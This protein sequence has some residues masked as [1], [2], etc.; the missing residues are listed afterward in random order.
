V[1]EER[2]LLSYTLTD[3]GSLSGGSSRAYGLNDAGQVVGEATTPDGTR[4]FLWDSGVMTDLGTLGRFGTRADAINQAG[5]VVGSSSG[6]AF[7]WQ[8]GVLND[9]L[10]L[11]GAATGINNAGQVV[12]WAQLTSSV[13]HAFLWQDGALTDLGT[14]DGGV[15]KADAVNDGRGQ[16]VGSA[17]V[18]D[19]QHAFLWQSGVM[20]DLGTLPNDFHSEATAI[21]SAGHV[22]GWSADFDLVGFQAFFSDGGPLTA[23]GPFGSMALGINDSDQVVGSMRSSD[24]FGTHAFLYADG[25]VTDLNG[26]IPPDSRFVLE[27]A[28]AINNSGQIVGVGFSRA[29]NLPRAFLLTPDG[30]PAPHGHAASSTPVDV[31]LV[32]GAPVTPPDADVPLESPRVAQGRPAL[33]GPLSA[34]PEFAAGQVSSPAAGTP[35]S[36]AVSR[37]AADK[38]FAP[39]APDMLDALALD[40]FAWGPVG[41][42]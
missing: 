15:S 24:T 26:L 7:L 32:R 34:G 28:Q 33:R 18:G 23:I 16:V 27:A 39:A 30:G 25:V 19:A 31:A 20:T 42:W 38:L 11:G 2:C 17:S 40:T 8:D 9:L 12:G 4:A 10:G 35:S 5:Q 41:D 1:L 37:H 29:V 14:L 22:A 21:N 6:L 13:F 36:A 3:L